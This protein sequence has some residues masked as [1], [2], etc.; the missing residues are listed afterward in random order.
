MELEDYLNQFWATIILKLDFDL[1]RRCIE[2]TLQ[3]SEDGE[4]RVHVIKFQKIESFYYAMENGTQSDLFDQEPWEKLELSSIEFLDSE[5]IN[6]D[7]SSI[8][9]DWIRNFCANANFIIEIWDSYLLLKSSK[10][11]I[12]KHVF[13]INN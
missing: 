12:D 3:D 13:I 9:H 1:K 2:I 10:V 4:E 11:E 8:Q 6:I 7:A 5:C